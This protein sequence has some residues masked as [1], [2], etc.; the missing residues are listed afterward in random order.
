[1]LNQGSGRTA[2]GLSLIAEP[3]L[4]QSPQ[5]GHR[6]RSWRSC[7]PGAWDGT[8]LW[9]SVWVTMPP[10]HPGSSSELSEL[11]GGQ[12]LSQPSCQ[13]DTGQTRGRRAS[14][15]P[16]W[17][18][19]RRSLSS[20]MMTQASRVHSSVSSPTGPTCSQLTCHLLHDTVLGLGAQGYFSFF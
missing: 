5:Q 15:A 12:L 7:T 16:P 17:C 2:L 1:M 8:R 14:E 10:Q 19:T 20:T 18:G 4:G 11:Q 13:L 6:P 9:G 3:G